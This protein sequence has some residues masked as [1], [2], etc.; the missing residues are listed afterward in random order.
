MFRTTHQQQCS[1]RKGD[2]EW[3]TQK[4]KMEVFAK[5][6]AK[7]CNKSIKKPVTTGDSFG[8][9]DLD[10]LVR[11]C[12]EESYKAENEEQCKVVEDLDQSIENIET[13]NQS[14]DERETNSPSEPE[15]D[16]VLD[17]ASR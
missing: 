6:N 15:Q 9:L 4:C 11:K 1:L 8:S 10:M 16:S 13:E 12:K 3:V 7:L 14:E 5:K 2:S 17:D